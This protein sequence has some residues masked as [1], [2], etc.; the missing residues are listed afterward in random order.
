MTPWIL[1]S[2]SRS[3]VGIFFEDSHFQRCDSRKTIFVFNDRS[4]R[5]LI[6]FLTG[7]SFLTARVPATIFIFSHWP[8]ISIFHCLLGVL[9]F[10]LT[11]LY[12][13][14]CTSSRTG[15]DAKSSAKEFEWAGVL[16]WTLGFQICYNI[17]VP[18]G[19]GE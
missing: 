18:R 2:P 12:H 16:H 19:E 3:D 11:C 14:I 9:D 7:I 1:F 15:Q 17:I 5:E 4:L 13:V 10:S 8:H 6:S